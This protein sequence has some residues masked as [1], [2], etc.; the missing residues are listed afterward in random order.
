MPLG[1]D[2]KGQDRDAFENVP[3]LCFIYLLYLF[4]KMFPRVPW[5]ETMPGAVVWQAD[6]YEYLTS[7][8]FPVLR[9]THVHVHTQHILNWHCEPLKV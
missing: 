1:D 2:Y 8:C 7:D 4:I 6:S 9:C 3:S 5:G